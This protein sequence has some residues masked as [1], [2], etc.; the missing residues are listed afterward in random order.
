M[1]VAEHA[2]LGLRLVLS[3]D[4]LLARL[5]HGPQLLV[6]LVLNPAHFCDY[7]LYRLLLAQRNVA[8]QVSRLHYIINA[9]KRQSD[10]A[11]ERLIK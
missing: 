3:L 9:R 5:D 1:T 11:K 2:F 7:R 6:Q 10:R 8:G 4:V